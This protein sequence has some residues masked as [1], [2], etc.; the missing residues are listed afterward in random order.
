MLRPSRCSATRERAI[1]QVEELGE[2]GTRFP[3]V[4]FEP[5]GCGKTAWLEQVVELLICVICFN[6]MRREFLA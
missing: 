5:E 4:I 6:P 3:V 1:R 2:R